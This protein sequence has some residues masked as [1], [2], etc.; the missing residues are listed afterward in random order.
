MNNVDK[1]S[2]DSKILI[3]SAK[4]TVSANVVSMVKSNAL[5]L[6]PAQLEKILSVINISLDEGYQKALPY[7]QNSIKK[8]F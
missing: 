1:I 2:R 6:E 4:D 8:Y 5:N 7:Y 3:D